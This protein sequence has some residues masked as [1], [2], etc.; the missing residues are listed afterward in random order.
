MVFMMNFLVSTKKTKIRKMK[1]EAKI[2]NLTKFDPHIKIFFF[3]TTKHEPTKQ[4]PIKK[5][6]KNAP[7]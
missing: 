2:K 1:E 6:K 3:L 5:K 7:N 4:T